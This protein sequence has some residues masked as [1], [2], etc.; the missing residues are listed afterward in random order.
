MILRF[1]QDDMLS[2]SPA[3]STSF[4]RPNG[5]RARTSESASLPVII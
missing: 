3:R 4:V 5:E 1:A 2:E